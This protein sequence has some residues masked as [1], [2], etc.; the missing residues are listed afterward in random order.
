MQWTDV[1]NDPCLRDLPYKI[2]LNRWGNIEM[3]PASNRHGAYQSRMSA[4]L[5]K[6]MPIGEV[7]MECS[8][9]TPEGVKVPDVAWCSTGFLQ[10]HGFETPY[11]EAPELCVE[12]LSP[13]NSPWEMLEKVQIYL[14]AGA[15]EAWLVSEEGKIAFYDRTGQIAQSSFNV[16][17]EDLVAG[18]RL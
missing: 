7:I 13:S 8:V 2:E 12:I 1:I 11:S 6:H 5:S 3:S 4:L 15:V 17:A 10:R 16:A 14:T 9:Q 18:L